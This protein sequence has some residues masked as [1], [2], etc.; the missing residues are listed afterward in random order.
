MKAIK[1]LT[2]SPAT[3]T[4]TKRQETFNSLKKEKLFPAHNTDYKTD[5]VYEQLKL[6]YDCKCAF[7]QDT[8]LNSPKHIEHYRSKNKDERRKNCCADTSYFWLAF[9][10]DNLLLACTSC[11]SSKGSCFDILGTRADYENK[12]KK[13]SL[14]DL[15]NIIKELDSTEKP[16]LVNPEQEEQS[17]FDHNLI[18]KVT[19]KRSGKSLGKILSKNMRLRYTIRI[20]NLNRDELI[21][22]RLLIINDLRNAIRERKTKYMLEHKDKKKY[23]EDIALLRKDLQNKLLTKPQFSALYS[24]FDCHFMAFVKTIEY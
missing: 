14:S 18:F 15:Q 17:F 16:L 2:L 9:S 8:L 5:D 6:I 21:Q 3:L 22:L 24:Y 1:K 4:D 7:C 23:S 10:W 20:C 19:D 12:Y 11:N 13:Y